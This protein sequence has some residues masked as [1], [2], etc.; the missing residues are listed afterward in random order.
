MPEAS[1]QPLI[2]IVVLNWNGFS[3][4]VDCFQSLRKQSYKNYKVILVDNGSLN[5]EGDRL[6][7][8]FPE[9]FLIKNQKNRGFAG[10]NNDAIDWAIKNGFQYI[11]CLNN[12]CIV[13]EEW[14][15]KLINGVVESGA[16][17]GSSMIMYH[18]EKDIICSDNDV[19]FFDG[20]V[21]SINQ[22][23]HLQKQDKVRPI[24]SACAAASI[25][26][27]RALE[28][29]KLK[30]KQYFDEMFFA[31]CE[32]ADL[33]IRLM[34]K[35]FKGVVVTDAIVYHKFSKTSGSGSEF[36]NYYSSRNRIIN[37]LLNFPIWVVVFGEFFYFLKSGIRLFLLMI[38][39][40]GK[41]RN[42]GKTVREPGMGIL[43]RIGVMF[44]ARKWIISNFKDIWED[45]KERKKR[46]FIKNSILR[47]ID[48]D[49]RHVTYFLD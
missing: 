7:K 43:E 27:A 37:L 35:S 41:K 26:S 25:Y 42:K 32:D 8:T 40:I 28:N 9:I 4:T 19:I 2:G 3:D 45:R 24:F 44:A 22:G 30:Q 21:K 17:Y 11:I 31:Y 46:G 5:E 49:V 23:K 47:Y 36:K 12:D 39:R 16:D 10:G 33:S 34:A 13:E 38:V 48:W 14:L 18:P 29:V 1:E 6:K 20:S 15:G